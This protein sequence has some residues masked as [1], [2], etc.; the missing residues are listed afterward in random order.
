MAQNGKRGGQSLHARLYDKLRILGL[1]L[2]YKNI[3]DSSTDKPFVNRIGM[4]KGAIV[5][6]MI[7]RFLAYPGHIY[8]IYMR[9]R[10]VNMEIQ[11]GISATYS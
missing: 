10:V 5:S 7:P 9:F 2:E 6:L 11:V 8:G 3:H 4:V 1:M